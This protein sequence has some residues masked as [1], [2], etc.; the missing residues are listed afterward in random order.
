MLQLSDFL[1]SAFLDASCAGKT[2]PVS[3]PQLLLCWPIFN[4]H[5]VLSALA[6]NAKTNQHGRVD[7][8]DTL[9]HRLVELCPVGALALLF[10]AQF[11]ILSS[12]LPEFTPDFGHPNYGEFGYRPWYE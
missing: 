10:Y 9:H 2:V 4:C 6:D 12:P 1:S 7:E 3:N 8:H 11:H 5:Q